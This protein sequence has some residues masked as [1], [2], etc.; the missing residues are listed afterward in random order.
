MVCAAITLDH[1][2]AGNENVIVAGVYR[3]TLTGTESPGAIKSVPDQPMILS[4]GTFTLS[5]ARS[6]VI[7]MTENSTR[8]VESIAF[9]MYAPSA[10]ILKVIVFPF[11]ESYS[12]MALQL[13]DTTAVTGVGHWVSDFII[14]ED[15]LTDWLT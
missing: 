5:S 11:T 2:L 8:I 4:L 10:G 13:S 15:V 3:I 14:T 9:I 12:S 6:N 1:D 7:S